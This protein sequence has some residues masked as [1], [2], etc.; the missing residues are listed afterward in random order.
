MK[1]KTY[2]TFEQNNDNNENNNNMEIP[3]YSNSVLLE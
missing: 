3:P 1:I 2:K